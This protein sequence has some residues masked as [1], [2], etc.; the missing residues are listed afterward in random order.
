VTRSRRVAGSGGNDAART[1]E[2]QA[3]P[4][5]LAGLE[6]RRD[7]QEAEAAPEEE[8]VKR[9]RKLGRAVATAALMVVTLAGIILLITMLRHA[10]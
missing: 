10:H 3:Q 2:D 9:L 5:A 8:Q 6:A 1:E 7:D 4:A